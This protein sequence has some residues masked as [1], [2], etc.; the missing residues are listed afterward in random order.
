M[1]NT[2]NMKNALLVIALILTPSFFFAQ[3]DEDE[4][5]MIREVI[6]VM[7]D[8]AKYVPAPAPTNTTTTTN[9]K[10][11][12]TKTVTEEPPANQD[13]TMPAPPA[14]LVKRANNWYNSKHKKYTK[15]AG[16]N[17]GTTVSC[18]AILPY[19][20][21]ELNPTHPVE[22]N[23]VMDV[24]IEAK[25]G[26]FRYTIKNIRHESKKQGYSGG[27]VF[28]T[29][30]ECGSMKISELTWKQIKSAALANAKIVAED[31]KLKMQQDSDS[32]SAKKDE[33]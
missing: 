16:T 3:G 25:E 32:H 20:P 7:V 23:I 21:K 19:K 27:D 33:W 12:K 10:G 28:S 14:E 5:K 17:A 18:K 6:T 22:G 11:K 24:V 4:S 26:K 2:Q 15:D 9:K 13:P 8:R 29:V 30:P 31:L 1:I